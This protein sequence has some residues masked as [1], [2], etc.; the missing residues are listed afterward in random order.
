MFALHLNRRSQRSPQAFPAHRRWC[1]CLFAGW[2]ATAAAFA[3]EPAPNANRSLRV[4]CYNIHHGRGLD[5]VVDLERLAAVIKAQ[6]PDLVSLQEVD[7]GTRRTAMVD[8]VAK[9]AELTGLS[10]HFGKQIDYE[11]GDYGQAILSR[12]PV[13]HSA[14]HWLPGEPNR[15]QRIAYAVTVS[16][17]QLPGGFLTFVTTH[18]HH[19]HEGFRRQ[20][21]ETLNQLVE[22]WPQP[23]ILTG[24]LNA[25]PDSVPLEILSQRWSNATSGPQLLTFPAGKPE[26]QLD[27]ILF[28]PATAFTPVKPQ[29]IDGQGASDHLPIFVELRY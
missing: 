25:T 24:D 12:F 28:H 16:A 14:V 15:E 13:T 19:Q 5:D 2:L 18:L 4:L 27:Y 9:L 6:Q 29:V 1:L 22:K 17:P 10:G 23:V 20:Q 11:G 8:Q 3:D 26:R 7:R 21:A